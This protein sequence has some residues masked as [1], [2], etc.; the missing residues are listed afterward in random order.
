V[1]QTEEY[2][3][4]VNSEEVIG[5]TERDVIYEVSCNLMSL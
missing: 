5:T 2:N 1:V 4:K 3:V